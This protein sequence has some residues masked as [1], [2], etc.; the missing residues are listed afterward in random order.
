MLMLRAS[1]HLALGKS[2]ELL[3]AESRHQLADAGHEAAA[4]WQDRIHDLLELAEA[5]DHEGIRTLIASLG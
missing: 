5:G 2:A 1:A 3:R 4:S